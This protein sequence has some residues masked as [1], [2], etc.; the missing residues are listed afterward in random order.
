MNYRIT[1]TQAFYFFDANK[2]LNRERMIISPNQVFIAECN[3]LVVGYT[4]VTE[5]YIYVEVMGAS[6][7]EGTAN[8]CNFGDTVTFSIVDLLKNTKF[9]IQSNNIET[10]TPK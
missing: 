6:S 4:R 5:R 3:D 2:I 1:E 10:F 7:L 8:Y 9:V